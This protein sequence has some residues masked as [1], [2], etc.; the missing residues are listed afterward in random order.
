MTI[1][2]RTNPPRLVEVARR[3]RFKNFAPIPGAG[4]GWILTDPPRIYLPLLDFYVQHIYIPIFSLHFYSHL[5]L[6]LSLTFTFNFPHTTHS[7]KP[8]PATMPISCRQ[9]PHGLTP[10]PTPHCHTPPP[11]SLSLFLSL[12]HTH[13]HILSLSHADS[14]LTK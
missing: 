8:P 1:L 12:T 2:N 3:L 14:S 6:S 5:S 7:L 10:S 9:T 4:R 13:T 11:P